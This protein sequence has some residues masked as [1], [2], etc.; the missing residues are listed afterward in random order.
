MPTPRPSRRAA[1]TILAPIAV[2]AAVLL[3]LS[4]AA[5]IPAPSTAQPTDSCAELLAWYHAAARSPAIVFDE[6]QE[7]SEESEEAEAA[8]EADSMSDDG[9]AIFPQSG[10]GGGDEV[11]GGEAARS[12]PADLGQRSETGTNVQVAGVDESDIVKTNGSEIFVMRSDGLVVVS[13]AGDAPSVIGGLRFGGSYA[14]NADGPREMLLAGDRLLTFRSVAYGRAS[15]G[16]RGTQL[17]EI[18]VSDPARPRVLRTLDTYGRFVTARLVGDAVRVVLTHDGVN[19]PFLMPGQGGWWYDDRRW[20]ERVERT[21]LSTWLP[22]F[23]L[24]DHVNARWRWGRLA[25]CGTV[26]TAE[27]ADPGIGTETTL[28]LNFDLAEGIGQWGAAGVVGATDAV[29]ASRGAVYVAMRDWRS[30]SAADT[31]I[32][33]WDLPGGGGAPRY[34]GEAVVA[35]ELV[36]QFAMSE[37][38][39]HLRVASTRFDVWPT[40]NLLTVFEIEDDGLSQLSLLEGLGPSESIYAVRFLGELGYVVTFRQIDPLYVL[41][42]SD[43]AEPTVAGELKIPGF[44]A[45]L[46]PLGGGLLLGIGQ[47]A[48][49]RTGQPLG[50]QASLF[51]VSEPA[52]PTRLAQVDL[53]RGSR[54]VSFEH[55]AFTYHQGRAYIPASPTNDLFALRVSEDSLELERQITAQAPVLRS[56]PIGERLHLLLEASLATHDL[57]SLEL[58]SGV[59]LVPPSN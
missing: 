50:L 10:G 36:N 32:H 26:R 23:S 21:S 37:Y 57:A 51:D 31:T 16:E 14:R 40:T 8:V 7:E 1:P 33:R 58:L 19:S 52:E 49:P 18:D 34:R 54:S 15:S 11:T 25:P 44:S 22:I 29:Y 45:Y 4:V 38:D 47:N 13:I 56:L 59:Y 35:G 24:V 30:W 39:G 28:L 55:R 43:P 17:L 42:L 20:R 6:P 27:R 53:S 46:H 9:A 2:L 48:D 12:A 41:D 5:L 3:A